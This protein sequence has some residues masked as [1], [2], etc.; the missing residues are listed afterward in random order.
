MSE[1]RKLAFI[2]RDDLYSEKVPCACK[3]MPVGYTLGETILYSSLP[4]HG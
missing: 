4:A 1:A 2:R 3:Q